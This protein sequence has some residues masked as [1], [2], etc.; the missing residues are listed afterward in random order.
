MHS[1]PHFCHRP[2]GSDSSHY[3]KAVTVRAV[4]LLCIVD[5]ITAGNSIV[6]SLQF[7]MDTLLELVVFEVDIGKRLARKATFDGNQ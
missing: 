5:V 4:L 6:A 1:Y 3:C 7:E 2:F